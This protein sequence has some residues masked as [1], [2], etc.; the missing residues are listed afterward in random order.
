MV[1]NHLSISAYGQ[2]KHQQG[3]KQKGGNVPHEL[4]IIPNIGHKKSKKKES[5]SFGE[6]VLSKLG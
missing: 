4:F 2:K 6:P 3:K 5:T 1:T